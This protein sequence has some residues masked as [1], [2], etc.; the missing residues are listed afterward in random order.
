LIL[1]LSA[2][3]DELFESFGKNFFLSGELV[4]VKKAI[5]RFCQLHSIRGNF[6]RRW[7]VLQSPVD[8]ADNFFPDFCGL[9][10]ASAA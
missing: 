10:R 4:F 8:I 5:S 2:R 3:L 9:D 7:G 6:H 1:K